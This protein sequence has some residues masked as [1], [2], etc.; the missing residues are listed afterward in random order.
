MK[1]EKF[2]DK[3]NAELS[4]SLKDSDNS[5]SLLVFNLF[6]HL[7]ASKD[8]DTYLVFPLFRHELFDQQDSWFLG[9]EL[10]QKYL[11]VFDNTHY[12][13][14]KQN[15]M[16]IGIAKK[17][18]DQDPYQALI[19]QYDKSNAAYNHSMQDTSLPLGSGDIDTTDEASKNAAQ[20]K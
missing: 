8:D 7:F 4:I 10:M 11:F 3:L 13:E 15:F 17:A 19:V 16:T 6:E 1:K 9:S 18:D 14:R 5:K 2:S 12:D 20:L